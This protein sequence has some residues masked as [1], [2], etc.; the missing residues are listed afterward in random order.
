M[1]HPPKFEN[2][3]A[4]GSI[5]NFLPLLVIFFTFVAGWTNLQATQSR[6]ELD[7]DRITAQ[8]TL[9]DSQTRAQIA[10]N[11]TR[12]RALENASAK[13]DARFTAQLEGMSQSLADMKDEMKLNNDMLR[14]ILQGKKL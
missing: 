10:L 13:S 4:L 9:T 12:I 6:Q 14:Q 11:E 5:L 8:I 3:I 7:V 1:T 2:K